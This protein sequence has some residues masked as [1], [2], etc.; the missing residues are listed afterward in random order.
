MKNLVIAK[1]LNGDMARG[2]TLDIGNK[3][4]FHLSTQQNMQITIKISDLKAVFF[5]KNIFGGSGMSSK[6]R[7]LRAGTQLHIR[8]LDDEEMEGVSFDYQLKKTQFFIFPLDDTDNNER[9]LINR[10][11]CRAVSMVMNES[12]SRKNKQILQRQLEMEIYKCLYTLAQE[13]RNPLEPVEEAIVITQSLLM[14]KKMAPL[15]E[16][17]EENFGRDTWIEFAWK[18]INEIRFDIGDQVVEPL[19]KIV[20]RLSA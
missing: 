6:P 12:E 2:F 13:F 18:K 16:K 11:A 5:V 8:F 1:Y 14:R 7:D 20:N 10:A 9:I 4:S 17:Y 15:L 3:D 19:T